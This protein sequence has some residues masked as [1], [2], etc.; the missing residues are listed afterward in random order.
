MF[1]RHGSDLSVDSDL[2][3]YFA[4]C[5]TWTGPVVQD[6]FCVCSE[7]LSYIVNMHESVQVLMGK[8]LNSMRLNFCTLFAIL[9]RYGEM[10]GCHMDGKRI[11]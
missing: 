10:R 2:A 5:S 4:P 8:F 9:F 6:C 1:G 11:N 7:A 3:Q